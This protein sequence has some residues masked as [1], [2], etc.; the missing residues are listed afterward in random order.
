MLRENFGD[1][2]L[3]VRDVGML[4]LLEFVQFRERETDIEANDDERGAREEGNAPPPGHEGLL[5]D[6][7]GNGR[8][9]EVRKQKADRAGDLHHAPEEAF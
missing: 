8:K 2:R 7:V 4:H 6:H 3:R 1:R 5:R 9:R